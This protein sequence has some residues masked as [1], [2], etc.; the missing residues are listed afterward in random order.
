VGAVV[1][2]SGTVRD[3]APGRDGV[4][5][6][7]Y[8]AYEEAAVDRLAEVVADVRRRWPDVRRVVAVHRIGHLGVGECAVVVAVGAPHRGSAFAAAAHCIDTLKATVPLW[9]KETWADGEEWGTDAT[10]IADPHD[11]GRVEGPNAG[12]VGLAAAPEAREI[13]ASPSRRAERA[14]AGMIA[15]APR[16]EPDDR[17]TDL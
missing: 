5:S 12:P 10:P 7:T 13:S 8:E 14:S 16:R 4:T 1:T 6:L 2:F 15:A 17:G 9:K 11:R 3:H